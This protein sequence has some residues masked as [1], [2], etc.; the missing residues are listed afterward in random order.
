VAAAV[1]LPQE[2]WKNCGN[3]P[4]W[5]LPQNKFESC[6]NLKLPREVSMRTDESK[7]R[8]SDGAADQY[9]GSGMA[10]KGK[11][12]PDG[13]PQP[14]QTAEIARG[15]AQPPVNQPIVRLPMETQ[16]ILA[17]LL[18]H[19]RGVEFLRSFSDIDGTFTPR[20]R[21]ALTYWYFRTTGG[22][23]SQVKD[24]YIGPD[25]EKTQALMDAYHAGRP[26]AEAKT[27]RIKRLS[28]MLRVSGIS[29]T[30]R[31]ST[32][33]IKGFSE[34]GVFRLGG[35]LIGTHAFRAI[36]NALAVNWPAALKTSD[37]DFGAFARRI[38]FGIL[39]TPQTMA[40]IPKAVEALG[41]GFVPSPRIALKLREEHPTSFFIPGTEWKIDLLTAQMGANREEPIEIPRFG[42]YAQ[43]L[44]FMDYLLEK[45]ME[46]VII[47]PTA[48]L[49]RVP[50]PARFAVHKLLVASNRGPQ[51]ALKADKDRLQ[52]ALL[53][54]FL[55][56]EWPGNLTL[57]TEEAL[58]RGPKWAKRIRQEAERL[59]IPCGELAE[60][61]ALRH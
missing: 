26:A 35:V 29:I 55:E 60:A 1:F 59:P 4:E 33:I 17:E 13:G 57:A 25:S 9:F 40:H 38:D 36:G 34:A 32:S 43:P 19:L 22:V 12:I 51:A 23:G 5:E 41:M 44:T 45:S 30:D 54:S 52:A 21:G 10:G 37:V 16:T 7:R 18:E 39:Q 15:V 31:E 8:Q 28:A 47:G 2:M 58:S 6:G 11:A 56:S 42:A 49:V 20:Q 14:G 46:A 53:M 3:D 27:D 48:V 24:F 50:D 61:L